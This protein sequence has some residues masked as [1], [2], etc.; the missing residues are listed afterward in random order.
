[1]EGLSRTTD[2]VSSK[3][4]AFVLQYLRLVWIVEYLSRVWEGKL[5]LASR[6][7]LKHQSWIRKDF[8]DLFWEGRCSH[9]DWNVWEDIKPNTKISNY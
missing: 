1:M 2:G 5:T 9:I 4:H 3:T 7:I 6:K 8:S